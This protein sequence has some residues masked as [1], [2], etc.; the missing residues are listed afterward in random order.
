MSQ[1]TIQQKVEQTNKEGSIIWWK[2]KMTDFK[3]VL[4]RS[5]KLKR[6]KPKK[7]QQLMLNLKLLLKMSSK[8]RTLTVKSTKMW[9]LWKSTISNLRKNSN[10]KWSILTTRLIPLCLMTRSKKLK[11]RWRIARY[12]EV[13]LMASLLFSTQTPIKNGYHSRELEY[14]LLEHCIWGHSLASMG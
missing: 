14:F 9:S 11:S 12:W 7:E 13:N 5:L 10:T 2:K 8:M 3:G 4:S 6:K 1:I